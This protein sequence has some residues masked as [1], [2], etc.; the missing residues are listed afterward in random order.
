MNKRARVSKFVF[1][2]VSLV[3]GVLLVEIH[4]F[5]IAGFIVPAYG[6]VFETLL[7]FLYGGYLL[8]TGFKRMQKA[9]A[10][11]EHVPWWKQPS[12]V[13]GLAFECFAAMGLWGNAI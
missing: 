3:F 2:G 9:K 11:G 12:I 1:F 4:A 7:F 6:L 10:Q 5:S 13:I 8:F